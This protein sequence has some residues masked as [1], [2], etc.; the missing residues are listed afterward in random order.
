MCV[1]VCK[2]HTTTSE[3]KRRNDR[4]TN[5]G[6]TETAGITHRLVHCQC[7]ACSV[8]PE[9][10]GCKRSGRC[11]VE[12]VYASKGEHGGKEAGGRGCC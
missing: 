9:P 3:V 2:A 8:N 7:R 1:C 10:S 12:R 11:T 5:K 4:K 6:P